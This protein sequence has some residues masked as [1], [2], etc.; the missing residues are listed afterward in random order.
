LQISS[1]RIWLGAYFL[2]GGLLVGCSPI[3]E[4]AEPTDSPTTETPSKQSDPNSEISPCNESLEA[5]FRLT[6]ESQTDAF[7]DGDFELAYSF[8][9]E[10]FRSN[11]SLQSFV[12]IIAGSYGPL[13]ESSNLGFSNCRADL[14]AGLGVIDVQF[15]QSG[16]DV[17]ALRYLLEEDPEGWRIGGATN[18]EV[19]G[20]GA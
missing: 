15:V 12:G 6:I 1:S 5:R 18:L 9:S 8:A 2:F 14:D 7:G 4:T 10:E 19:L 16:N 3:Q 17:Y 11:V 20:E 13:I